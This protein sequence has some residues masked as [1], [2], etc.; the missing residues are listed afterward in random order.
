MAEALKVGNFEIIREE[1][2][3][4]VEAGADVLDINI[5][6]GLEEVT[7]LPRVVE[8][9]I[10]IVDVP[11]CLDSANPKALEAAL[12]LY[13]GKPI[14]NSVTGDERSLKDILPLVKQYGTAVIGLAMD[15][16]CVPHDVNGRVRVASKI[17]DRAVKLG[18]P[19]EDIIIDCI[20]QTAGADTGAGVVALQSIRKIKETVG[21]NIALGASNISFGLP[22]RS[23]L[24]G[25]FVAI[26]IA[27]GVTCPIV[28]VAQVRQVVTAADLILGRDDYAQRYIKAYRSQN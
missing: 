11:L 7:M 10:S 27:A 1:A 20:V 23:L 13:R 12:R 4:Q 28:D 3:A 25:I 19:A 15:G 14:I 5:G 22:N 24:N 8:A 2:V 17:M 9:V 21:V 18:I 16:E 26:A 6:G